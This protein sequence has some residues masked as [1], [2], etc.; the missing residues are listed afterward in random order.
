M[1]RLRLTCP[2]APGI[3]R[4]LR[5]LLRTLSKFIVLSRALR[6][7]RYPALWG[8]SA[9]AFTMSDVNTDVA[10][11]WDIAPACASE[12]RASAAPRRPTHT[13]RK[14]SSSR[15]ENGRSASHISSTYT[16]SMSRCYAAISS[17]PFSAAEIARASGPNWARHL[18]YA[19]LMTSATA[20]RSVGASR[21]AERS[22]WTIVVLQPLE[23]RHQEAGP[24]RKVF[25]SNWATDPCF[26]GQG[27]E[28]QFI[29]TLIADD[30]H[31]DIQHLL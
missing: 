30:F 29:R 18:K 25:V 22:Q 11:C 4:T 23:Q 24:G 16:L 10:I 2:A 3:G 28:R 1:Q 7:E 9:T 17:V 26:S 5:A 14:C 6:Q 8:P 13:G 27:P 20:V 21:R 31:R 15:P 19:S 12:A